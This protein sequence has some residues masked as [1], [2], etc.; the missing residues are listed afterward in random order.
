[1][2]HTWGTRPL[3][4]WL[5]G[6]VRVSLLEASQQPKKEV[7]LLLLSFVRVLLEIGFLD[8]NTNS[9][10]TRAGLGGQGE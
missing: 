3:T 6:D 7:L 8:L 2:K 4:Q 5:V 9:Q 10:V 1:M